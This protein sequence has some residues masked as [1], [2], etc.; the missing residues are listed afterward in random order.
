MSS[1]ALQRIY[2]DLD[3]KCVNY[4]KCQKVLKI[5]DIEAHEKICS[6]VEC[7]NFEICGKKADS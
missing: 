6:Q 4:E 7:K 5:C 2:N 1:K 3:I